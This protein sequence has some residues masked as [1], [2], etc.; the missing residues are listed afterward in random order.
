MTLFKKSLIILVVFFLI[1]VTYF[2]YSFLDIYNSQSIFE[3]NLEEQMYNLTDSN[4]GGKNL[5]DQS[6][7]DTQNH[8]S[9]VNEDGNFY[10]LKINIESSVLSL[11]D[12]TLI[13]DGPVLISETP[14]K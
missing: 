6:F 8:Y 4:S 3:Q 14:L 11:Y 5:S 1:I 7:S 12:L 10:I 13:Q 9:F 2:L